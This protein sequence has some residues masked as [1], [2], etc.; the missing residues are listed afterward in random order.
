[1][2][3]LPLIKWLGVALVTQHIVKAYQGEQ[4][5]VILVT[6]GTLN[7]S[8]KMERF[9]YMDKCIPTHLKEG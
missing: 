3:Y 9:S 4:G 2:R 8:N 1:M 7:S 6:E 5:N